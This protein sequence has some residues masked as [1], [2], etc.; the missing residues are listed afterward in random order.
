MAD[1]VSPVGEF[2]RVGF[3]QK[4]NLF[5]KNRGILDFLMVNVIGCFF[6]FKEDEYVRH[7]FHCAF[8]AGQTVSP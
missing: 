6:L 3:S 1:W 7:Y 2:Y 4:Q 5:Y 8:P